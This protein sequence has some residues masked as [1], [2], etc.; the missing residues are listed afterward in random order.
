[1]PNR[2][3]LDKLIVVDLEATCWEHGPPPGEE[4]EIVEIGLCLLDIPTGRLELKRS[5]LIRPERSRLSPFCSELTTLTQEQVDQGISFA[6]ACALLRGEYNSRRRIWASYGD[7]DRRQLEE[8]C[9]DRGVPY[10]FG[11]THLNVKSLA[12]LI[13]RLEQE[14]PLPE[15]LAHFGWKLEGVY[16]RGDDDAWNIARLLRALLWGQH[17]LENEDGR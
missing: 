15:A 12:A 3:R 4:S 7:Y 1:M 17:D 5:I 14:V 6:E 13:L 16:H 10:P 8:Q 2:N 11:L 9:A